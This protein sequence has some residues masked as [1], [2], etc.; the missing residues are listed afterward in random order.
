[1]TSTQLARS[2]SVAIVLS[3]LALAGGC[4]ESHQSD[5]DSGPGT[6]GGTPASD[7]TVARPD[8][9]PTPGTDSG[10]PSTIDTGPPSM[11]DA[12]PP[13]PDV[14]SGPPGT[15]DAGPPGVTC[16]TDTC[17]DPQ[18]CCVDFGGG[19]MATMTCTAPAD[20][21][22]VAASCDGP[23]DCAA[24]EACCGMR[25]PGG[26]GGST[27]CVPD[28]MCTFGRLCHETA[29]CTGGDMC[30]AFMGANVCSPFCI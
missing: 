9:G 12:G 16:G 14:D 3:A 17:V 18:I 10:P 1:M 22:G 11:T 29:D 20:C 7:G 2:I 27:S 6:D 19:G 25:G 23:E 28:A 26:G 24:G 21:M 8:T 13:D 15:T 5:G 4:S 30:C